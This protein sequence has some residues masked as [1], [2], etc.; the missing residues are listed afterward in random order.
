MGGP[1]WV[2]RGVVYQS[3]P[4]MFDFILEFLRDGGLDVS[5]SEEDHRALFREADFYQLK[6]LVEVLKPS[7]SVDNWTWTETPNGV[8]S[9]GGLTF[10]SK[11]GW[12]SS[13]GTTG[14]THGVHEW[15][16]RIDAGNFINV[17]VSLENIN[18]N[19][20]IMKSAKQCS[21]TMDVCTVQ[22]AT[23]SHT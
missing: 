4:R 17:G 16:V 21:A 19:V 23:I 7:V 9:N 1:S 5:L 2:R 14:W 20:I 10:T 18:P 11:S 15:V 22:T 13:R 6:D 8:L 12:V 3:K